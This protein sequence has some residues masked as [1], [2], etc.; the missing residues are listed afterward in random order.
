M[1]ENGYRCQ[2]DTVSRRNR[3]L[4][5]VELEVVRRFAAGVACRPA[6]RAKLTGVNHVALKRREYLAGMQREGAHAHIP[7]E[8]AELHGEQ[9]IGGF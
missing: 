6:G 7:A 4:P 1:A 8:Q 2:M 9:R 3:L 5:S